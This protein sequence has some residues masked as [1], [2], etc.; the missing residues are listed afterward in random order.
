MLTSML[1][2]LDVRQSAYATTTLLLSRHRG[3]GVSNREEARIPALL[4]W[5]CLLP[6]SGYFWNRSE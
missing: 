5:L 3:S 2:R 4:K 6:Q 1:A